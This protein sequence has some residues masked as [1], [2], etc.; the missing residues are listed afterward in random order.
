MKTIL[1]YE[2]RKALE[3]SFRRGYSHGFQHGI[4]AKPE[5]FEK[6]EKE[7]LNWRNNLTEQVCPPASR[8]LK[9][10]E[11]KWCEHH[12]IG[13]MRDR[14]VK[15]YE[16]ILEEKGLKQLKESRKGKEGFDSE[17]NRII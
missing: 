14:F 13:A 16:E 10:V 5:E 3:E 8:R 1:D 11:S 6:L 9:G 17:G 7:V 2:I 15:S 4:S 12:E